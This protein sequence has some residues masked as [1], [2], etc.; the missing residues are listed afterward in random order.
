MNCCHVIEG[1]GSPSE[2]E[3]LGAVRKG[4][5]NEILFYFL[6]YLSATPRGMQ[7]LNAPDQGWNPCALQWKHGVLTTGP[8]GNSEN[9]Y[10]MGNK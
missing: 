3:I 8:P 7:D 4:G 10:F 9:E 6:S 1:K 5:K 2:K